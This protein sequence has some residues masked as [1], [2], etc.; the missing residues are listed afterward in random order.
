MSGD[1]PGTAGTTTPARTSATTPRDDAVELRRFMTMLRRRWRAIL[2]ATLL[3]L[4]GAML[5]SWLMT[6]QYEAQ[7][8]MFVSV[9]SAATVSDLQD[10]TSYSQQVVRT[11]AEL[12]TSSTVLAP[13]VEELD[14][15]VAPDELAEHVEAASQNDSVILQITVRDDEPRRAAEIADAVAASVAETATQIVPTTDQGRQPVA[16]TT[17]EEAVVPEDPVSPR[18]LLYA[19]AGLGIGASL[20][21]AGVALRSLLDTRLRTEE[22]ISP[23]TEVPVLG[24]IPRARRREMRTILADPDAQG[25]VP[26]AVRALR[27]TLQFLDIDQRRSIFTVTSSVPQEGKTTVT[28][29]LAASL[30]RAGHRV[31]VVDADL[32][33]PGVAAALGIEGA[34]GLADV[35]AGRADIEDVVQPW[36]PE[37]LHVLPAGTIPP[38]P[39]ELLASRRMHQLLEEMEQNYDA[40]LIDTPPLLAV[41]DAAVVAGRGAGVLLATGMDTVRRPQLRRSL[42]MLEHVGTTALGL[43]TTMV[44][45][46]RDGSGAGDYIPYTAR[47]SGTDG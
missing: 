27:T 25:A 44:P 5:I 16:F 45:L 31:L 10:G 9:D 22:E 47:R 8:R 33:R 41:G 1:T 32:R 14:L 15:P 18:P 3:G 35:L 17:V 6:P 21:I 28:V 20:G 4:G 12:S 2:A 29:A 46:S 19:A 42:E 7:T 30:R 40:V 11:V 38:N 13:V 36:G 43:V 24:R 26:E 23:I 34:V 39:Q 37:D